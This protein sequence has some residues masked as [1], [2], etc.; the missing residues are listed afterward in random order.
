MFPSHDQG[1][2]REVVITGS[3]FKIIGSDGTRT[4]TSDGATGELTIG[5]SS[6]QISIIGSAINLTGSTNF[7]NSV[8]VGTLT[9]TTKV[10]ASAIESTGRIDA[11]GRLS[12]SSLKLPLDDDSYVRG[13]FFGDDNAVD[14]RITDNG[15]DLFIGYDDT[16]VITLN[17]TRIII[18]VATDINSSLTASSFLSEGDTTINGT[19][20]TNGA[21]S[22]T[23]INIGGGN[24][25]V[26]SNG[27][28]TNTQV[29]K[30]TGGI[31][32]SYFRTIPGGATDAAK[33][34]DRDWETRYHL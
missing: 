24:F 9:A 14:T 7:A 20:F 34:F 22:P 16:D 29:A 25:E 8:T 23:S 28:V 27:D 33:L 26:N 5:N 4:F 11:E 3:E 12:G 6:K 1:G 21:F 32:A 19:L 17:G 30:F 18:D 15:T 10:T 13:I 2:D 31:S